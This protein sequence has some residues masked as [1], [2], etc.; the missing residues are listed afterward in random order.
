MPIPGKGR[1]MD[2]AR[3]PRNETRR[4]KTEKTRLREPRLPEWPTIY[5]LKHSLYH[6]ETAVYSMHDLHQI[7]THS[8]YIYTMIFTP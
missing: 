7:F 5:G 6:T 8:L 4:N 3:D 1:A 2:S